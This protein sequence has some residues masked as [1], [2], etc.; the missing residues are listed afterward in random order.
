MDTNGDGF[1]DKEEA[2][3]SAIAEFGGDDKYPGVEAKI[4]E[5]MEYDTNRD[6]KITKEEMLAA[7]YK[8][9]DEESA[10]LKASME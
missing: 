5:I 1:V 7:V 10:A 4:A 8:R 2:R 9:I 3:A 6:G